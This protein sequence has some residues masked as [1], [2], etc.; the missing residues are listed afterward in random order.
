MYIYIYIFFLYL[1]IKKKVLS[2]ITL[3]K[4]ITVFYCPIIFQLEFFT[5]HL[6]R[7]RAFILIRLKIS[8]YFNIRIY[9]FY[10]IQ[11]FTKLLTLNYLLYTLFS[12]NNHFLFFISPTNVHKH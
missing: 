11:H 2:R 9:I 1:P 7:F 10:F 4:A 8:V 6:Q 3:L 12:L 5:H